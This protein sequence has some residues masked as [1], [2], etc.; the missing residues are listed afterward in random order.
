MVGNTSTSSG[1]DV[2][3]EVDCDCMLNV[4]C[5]NSDLFNGGDVQ[6]IKNSEIAVVGVVFPNIRHDVSG[7]DKEVDPCTVISV[8]PRGS[9]MLGKIVIST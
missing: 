3:T 9:T 2:D 4:A 7:K 8:P 1:T 6:V 5:P